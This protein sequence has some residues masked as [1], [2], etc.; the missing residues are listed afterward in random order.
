MSASTAQLYEKSLKGNQA[1]E[2]STKIV[3]DHGELQ[4]KVARARLEVQKRGPVQGPDES[5]DHVQQVLEEVREQKALLRAVSSKTD[6]YRQEA[7]EV[8]ERTDQESQIAIRST[9]APEVVQVRKLRRCSWLLLDNTHE[10]REDNELVGL[11]NLTS[12]SALVTM[13][14]ARLQ[15]SDDI[16]LA[17]LQKVMGEQKDSWSLA[18]VFQ[19]TRMHSGELERLRQELEGMAALQKSNAKLTQTNSKIVRDYQ[20]WHRITQGLEA[21]LDDVKQ[22]Q[23]EEAKATQKSADDDALRAAQQKWETDSTK[24]MKIETD[25]YSELQKAHQEK[26]NGWHN[27]L[28]QLRKDVLEK[29]IDRDR[30]KRQSEESTLATS[31]AQSGAERLNVVVEEKNGLQLEVLSLQGKLEIADQKYGIE[32]SAKDRIEADLKSASEGHAAEAKRLQGEIAGLQAKLAELK[33]VDESLREAEARS[34]GMEIVIGQHESAA[35]M[36]ASDIANVREDLDKERE[37]HEKLRKEAATWNI[38]K[39]SLEAEVKLHKD[40]LEMTKKSNSE[41][42]VELTQLRKLKGTSETL[43]RSEASLKSERE[44]LR[45]ALV[46]VTEAE[47]RSRSDDEVVRK[48]L[49]G[50]CLQTPAFGSVDEK[51][52]CWSLGLVTFPPETLVDASGHAVR[53]LWLRTCSTGR[54]EDVVILVEQCLAWVATGA[55]ITREHQ[56]LVL[57]AVQTY[58]DNFDGQHTGSGEAARTMLRLFELAIR[59]RISPQ[60]L[61]PLWDRYKDPMGAVDSVLVSAL[62]EWLIDQIV[63]GGSTSTLLDCVLRVVQHDMVDMRSIEEYGN[64]TRVLI[65]GR[66]RVVLL[67]PANMF[68][69]DYS[70]DDITLRDDEDMEYE[71]ASLAGAR[72]VGDKLHC[73]VDP[74][75]IRQDSVG[76]DWTSRQLSI[77]LQRRVADMFPRH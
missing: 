67:D 51:A 17:E 5:E 23:V 1:F 33:L 30:Y 56:K 66:Q 63:N 53:R 16:D 49:A 26:W 21:E 2:R 10:M 31:A 8:A 45:I 72:R 58:V 68:V 48:I 3:L 27:Q 61:R 38:E 50:V 19:R 22:E 43:Q 7:K 18:E 75:W 35:K 73:V 9:P 65:A 52:L 64:T 4:K 14:P 76:R 12:M 32:K 25:R 59:V 6:E 20:E 46:A 24:K 77:V 69:T 34:S 40:T 74:F 13:P 71:V 60:D 15:P 70:L 29:E 11:V 62:I 47:P 57:A 55:S 44:M 42:V 39:K 28:E 37:W 36:H 54:P 41:Y